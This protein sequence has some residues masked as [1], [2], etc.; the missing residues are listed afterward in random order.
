MNDSC[1]V[2]SNDILLS[3]FWNVTVRTIPDLARLMASSHEMGVHCSPAQRGAEASKIETASTAMQPRTAIWNTWEPERLVIDSGPLDTGQ[4]TQRAEIWGIVV[5]YLRAINIRL[6]GISRR[7]PA[8]PQ[9]S[10]HNLAD[11]ETY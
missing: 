1:Q 8:K 4:C 3:F 5:I 9:R 6:R 11:F 10:R 2:T 7:T